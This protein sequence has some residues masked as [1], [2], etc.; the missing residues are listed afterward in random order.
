MSGV[1]KNDATLTNFNR[2]SQ[3][4]M[5]H[6]QVMQGKTASEVNELH[7]GDIGAVAKLKETTTGETLGDKSATIF[8]PP[9]RIPEPSIT[10]AI[11]PKTRADEDRIG[12]AIHKFSKRTWRCGSGATRRRRN[13]C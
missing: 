6:M 13:F 11:E 2:N 7:A 12:V 3:E 5:Q 4:R 10:F 9:A 8:Y 1:L